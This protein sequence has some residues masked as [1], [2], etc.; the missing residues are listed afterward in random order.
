MPSCTLC[1]YAPPIIATTNTPTVAPAIC[2]AA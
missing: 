1:A 2:A